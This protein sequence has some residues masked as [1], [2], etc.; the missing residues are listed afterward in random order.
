M[1]STN[2]IFGAILSNF[3][4][5]Y[6]GD[7]NVYFLFSDLG[8]LRAGSGPKPTRNLTRGS[9]VFKNPN[10]TGSFFGEPEVTRGDKFLTR[11]TRAQ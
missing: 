3:M 8:T 10:R 9:H 4:S 7:L 6:L 1:S 5:P 11:A 2:V